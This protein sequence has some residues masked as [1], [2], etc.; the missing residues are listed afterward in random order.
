MGKINA[1]LISGKVSSNNSEAIALCASQNFGEKIGEKV[2]YSLTE[3][4]Y[5]LDEEFKSSTQALNKSIY[6]EYFMFR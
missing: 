1:T 4:L 2:F 5:L 3:T 6:H